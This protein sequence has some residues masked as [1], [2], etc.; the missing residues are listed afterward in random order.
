MKTRL[1]DELDKFLLWWARGL[2]LLIPARWRERLDQPKTFVLLQRNDADLEIEIYRDGS[3]KPAARYDVSA[4][5]TSAHAS[6]RQQL[7]SFA[8]PNA[9]PVILRLRDDEVLQ[10]R[11]RYPRTVHK[12]LANV[13]AFDIDRQ[14]PFAR[15]D[16]YFDYALVEDESSSEHIALDLFVVP[17]NTLTGLDPL[18]SAIGLKPNIIDV[19]RATFFEN[20]TN[21]LPAAPAAHSNQPKYRLQFALFFLWL[22][23]IAFVPGKQA[24][25]A[26]ATIEA[27]SERE[28]NARNAVKDINALRQKHA[29]SAKK[30]AFFDTLETQRVSVIAMLDEVTRLLGDDTW[31]RRF[32]FKDGKLNLH[33]ESSRASEIPGILEG[34]SMFAA[35][36]FSSPVTRNNATGKD[37]F[38]LKV[39]VN[40]GRIQ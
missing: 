15:E 18:F 19:T 33:G 34:S 3:A 40:S 30:S 7:A 20:A 32:D 14:T 10:K 39:T 6:I 28:A 36:Q 13:V 23:L 8:A 5:D 1:L 26:R 22:L 35:P 25:E 2:G 4:S 17:R 31:I 29:A 37:R 12:D 11:L 38:Q 24:L 21:L 16:A 9:P 27:L